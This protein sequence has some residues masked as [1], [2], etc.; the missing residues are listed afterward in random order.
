MVYPLI[1]SDITGG[2]GG[3]GGGVV[4]RSNKNLKIFSTETAPQNLKSF[5]RN[6]HWVTF[7]KK[8]KA[9]LIRHKIWPSVGVASFPYVPIYIYKTLNLFS[10]DTNSQN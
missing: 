9:N 2:G 8:T 1:N 5:G 3:G 6:G 10:S 7:Y 4:Y